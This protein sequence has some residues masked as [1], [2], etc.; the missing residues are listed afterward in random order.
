MNIWICAVAK[1]EELYI[2]EWIE[3]NKKIGV[4]HIV[5]GDNNDSDY[6]KPLCPII[7]DYIND[8]Y[9]EV[10]NKNDIL[11]V[12]QH[13]YNEI[14]HSRK[15]NFDWIG[16]IDIDEFIEL[17]LYN[18]IHLFLS[19]NK[20]ENKDAII[21]CWKNFGDNENIYYNDKPVKERF[22]KSINSEV[23][24]IKYFIKGS[25]NNIDYLYS[26]HNPLN[27]K[28][29]DKNCPIICCDV[30]GNTE[31]EKVVTKKINHF[32]KIVINKEYYEVA[33]ISHY[34]TKSTEEYILYRALRGRC[35]KG[36]YN[37]NIRYTAEHYF[38]N[39]NETPEKLALF[40]KYK[41]IIK[42]TQ[43]KELKKYSNFNGL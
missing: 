3:W 28:Y 39:N 14:Y 17:P 32:S 20:F 31:F 33:Y 40:E 4:D 43:N 36:K 6:D 10:I 34:I 22:T 23:T 8:G 19:D 24:G 9:V 29:K 41:N 37:Y 18:D 2:R 11:N 27:T 30:L 35:D 25:L 7:Q 1:M 5:I 15:N 12:Q 13:F 21:L 16:F 42:D 26:I 38:N